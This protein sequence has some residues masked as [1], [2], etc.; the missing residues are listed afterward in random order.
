LFLKD[1]DP[2]EEDVTCLFRSKDGGTPTLS[3]A[4]DAASGGIEQTLPY[5]I[6]PGPSDLIAKA[7][8]AGREELILNPIWE[9]QVYGDPFDNFVGGAGTA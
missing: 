5:E 7:R 9:F 4:P 8:F 3:E 1:P 2:L 6:E